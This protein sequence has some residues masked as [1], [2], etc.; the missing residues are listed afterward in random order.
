MMA[1]LGLLSTL[2][3][4]ALLVTVLS[5]LVLLGLLMRD[6]KKRRLW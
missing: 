5:P 2:V 6:W 3:S 4:I 1:S